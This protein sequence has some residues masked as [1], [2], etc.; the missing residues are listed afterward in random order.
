MVQQGARL[1]IADL[2]EIRTRTES[3]RAG[4]RLGLAVFA[5][6]ELYTLATTSRPDRPFLGALFGLFA[7]CALLVARL[8]AERIVRSARRD[9]F[10]LSWSVVSIALTMAVVAVDGGASSPLSILF[11]VPMVFAALSYPVTGVVVVA[12]MSELGFVA[13]ALAT[14]ASDPTELGFFTACLALVAVMC[15]WQGHLH[16]RRRAELTVISR[17]DPLT[18]CLNRRGFEERL[19]SELDGGVRT[20]R[21]LSVVLIDVDDFKQINDVRG[22]AAGDEVLCW[23]TDT[24]LTAGRPMDAVGRLGGDEFAVMLPGAGQ[25]EGDAAATRLAAAL[26]PRVSVT[27]GVASFPNHGV[28]GDQLLAHADSELYAAKRG[29]SRAIAPG[30]RELSWAAAL[31]RAVDLRMAALDEHSKQVAAYAEGIGRQLGWTGTQLALLRI[32]GLLHDVGKVSVPDRILRKT[33]VLTDEEQREMRR[34]P[35]TGSD[36]VARVEGLEAIVPWILHSHEHMNGSG[37]PHGLSSDDI[38]LASRALLVADAFDAMTNERPYRRRRTH[39]EALAELHRFTGT[40][41]DPH[42]VAALEAYLATESESG[43]ASGSGPT[44]GVLAYAEAQPAPASA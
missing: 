8:P 25:A 17:A 44:P 1:D 2:S 12:A 3:V 5:A 15:A 30:R 37:Y 11:F 33:D 29:E 18:G 38:P 41:F 19:R 4:V 10:F 27:F 26:H 35:V 6:G 28:D 16:D 14:G 34:H 20:G 7:V 43:P 40:Q 36:L 23:L 39:E 21:P 31:A 13:V 22:H 24:L 42:C 32:A 9:V